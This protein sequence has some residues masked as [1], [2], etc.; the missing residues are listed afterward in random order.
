MSEKNVERG[1]PNDRHLKKTLNNFARSTARLLFLPVIRTLLVQ[2]V[3]HLGQAVSNEQQL[4][5]LGGSLLGLRTAHGC[6]DYNPCSPKFMRPGTMV[7]L[8]N[9]NR[10]QQ[11]A[12]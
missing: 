2:L 8:Q 5:P 3:Q 6:D 11:V 9:P 12:I 7:S 4:R 1:A 10:F